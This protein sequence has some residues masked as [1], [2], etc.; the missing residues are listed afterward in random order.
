MSSERV[1]GPYQHRNKWRVHIII[2]NGGES[3]TRYESFATESEA[4]KFKRAVERE[5]FRSK[6]AESL[7]T[8][9]DDLQK[10]VDHYNEEADRRD[11]RGMTVGIA[12]DQYLDYMLDVKRNKPL[13]I[14]TTRYQVRGLIKD[15]DTPLRGITERVALRMYEQRCTECKPDTHRNNLKVT[16]TFMKWCVTRGWIRR[17]PFAG[18]KGVGKRSQGKEQLRIDEARVLVRTA[19]AQAQVPDEEASGYRAQQRR[20]SALAV[21][22]AVYLAMR[23]K[24]IVSIR[25]RDVDDGGRVLWI[26]HSKSRNGRRALE[27]ADVLAPLLARRSS[28]CGDDPSALLFPHDRTWVRDNVK[29]LCRESGVPEIT[30]HGARGMH[31]TIAAQMG[32][33]SHLVAAA[34]GQ[35]RNG[36]VAEKHYIQPGTLEAARR[37]RFQEILDRDP[38]ELV[39]AM[40]DPAGE[41]GLNAEK[42]FGTETGSADPTEAPI[43]DLG[44]SAE[45]ETCSEKSVSH[46]PTDVGTGQ[47][48]DGK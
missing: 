41:I 40:A 2:S 44:E 34:L 11:G 13:S 32:A 1:N 16:R 46:V 19:L 24:E 10:L 22:V 14:E 38:G 48:E 7:R 21:L 15:L 28:E 4:S 23:S 36:V 47:G 43:G 3:Q 33:T 20:L 12:L 39:G 17:N 25:R 5:I 37:D 42:N 9:A 35:D 26:P 30:A 45:W 27:V 6:D 8:K 18:I 29:R 31:A